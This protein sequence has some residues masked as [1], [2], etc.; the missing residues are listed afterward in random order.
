MEIIIDLN[1]RESLKKVVHIL[2]E[3]EFNVDEVSNNLIYAS[4]NPSLLSWGENISLELTQIQI[5]KTKVL[6]QSESKA[7]VISWGKNDSNKI[8]IIEKLKQL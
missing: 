2:N 1:K 8:L 5:Q 3:L 4:S 7:Q 6:I